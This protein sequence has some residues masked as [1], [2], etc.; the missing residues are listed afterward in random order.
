MAVPLS[1]LP[2]SIAAIDRKRGFSLI[3]LLVAIA[4]I[5]V[6]LSLLGFSVG[7][8]RQSGLN[9]R[10]VAQ[11]RNIHTGL[12]AYAADHGGVIPPCASLP[13]GGYAYV[14]RKKTY[15][16]DAL[17]AYM[18]F[19]EYA[20][21]R[22]GNFPE[23]TEVDGVFPLAWQLCPAKKVFP[24]QRQNVGYG[25]NLSN[26]GKDYSAFVANPGKDT[27]FATRLSQVAEPSRTIIIGDSKDAGVRADQ[28][29]EDRYIYDY[30]VEKRVPYP[31]RHLGRGNYLFFDGHVEAFTPEQMRSPEVRKMMKKYQ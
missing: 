28:P 13:N 24:L 9:S 21:D 20:A 1:S 11:L 3:E 19:P 5:S 6:L 27:G 4:V 8:V 22:Q 12:L 29:H 7:K 14:F 17:N 31:E 16:F 18:G 23:P 10:C 26:F 30:D 25:W 2:I 15:W